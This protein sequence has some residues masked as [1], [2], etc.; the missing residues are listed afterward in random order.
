MR[1]CWAKREF[2]DRRHRRPCG[3]MDKAPDFGSGDCRFESCHDRNIFLCFAEILIGLCSQEK[4]IMNYYILE[5]IWFKTFLWK[6]N[7]WKDFS[8][9][10]P[11]GLVRFGTNLK[12]W[13]IW[14]RIF[15]TKGKSTKEMPQPWQDSNLQSPDPKSGAL[16]IRPHGSL[17]L[18][19][20]N[21]T[22]SLP[23]YNMCCNDLSNKDYQVNYERKM[24][25]L[26]QFW[27]TGKV[28]F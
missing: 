27:K 16:S 28:L 13:I 9:L 18:M 8:G 11:G 5:C 2:D 14:R 24:L 20:Y 4:R 23:K 3:L 25:L 6:K 19:Y 12:L 15:D 7:T 21:T 22:L 1:W 17:C 26:F 10:W